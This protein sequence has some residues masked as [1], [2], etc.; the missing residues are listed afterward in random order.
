MA[1]KKWAP[2]G[3]A[4]LLPATDPALAVCLLPAIDPALVGLEMFASVASVYHIYCLN[5]KLY[6]DER[7][8][9]RMM[10]GNIGKPSKN[11]PPNLP[12][13]APCLPVLDPHN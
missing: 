7:Q 11:V 1:L 12:L 13:P 10:P 6:M 5:L 3:T 4:R 8:Q 2:A 9:R